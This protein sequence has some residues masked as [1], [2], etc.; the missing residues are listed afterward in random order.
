MHL[1]SFC[2]VIALA[3]GFACY[4]EEAY[5]PDPA[6]P[7]YQLPEVL[8]LQSGKSV[9]TPEEWQKTR[10]G[11]VLELFRTHVY[12]RMPVTRYEQS[13]HV[14]HED[15]ETLGGKATLRQVEIRIARESKSL[16]IRVNLF[17]PNKSDAPVPA[18]VL[19]CNRGAE[20]I[21]PTR[22]KK[23]EFWPVEEGIARS[24]AMAAFLNADVD[25]DKD[26]GFKDGAHGLLDEGERQA[27][28][29]GTIAAWAW[30]A[31]RVLDYLQTVPQIDAKKVA[32]IGHSRGG[33][34][35]LWAAAEDQRFA[36]AVSNDSGCGGAAIS[37][38]RFTG[39][40]QVARITTA[41]PHWFCSNFKSYTDREDELPIDQHELIALI[42]PRAVA[43]GSSSEDRW[44]DPRGEYLSVIHAASVY[45]LFG[46][47]ALGK[48]DLPAI[49]NAIHG[50]QAH[51]HLRPGKHNL[52]LEDWKHYWDFADRV[53]DRKSKE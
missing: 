27:D 2:V 35:A 39:R 32:V 16:T 41:F 49:G 25:P 51:Y 26:D 22:E 9:T 46:H 36:L 17:F 12:G 48:A 38:R 14:T 30:G 45:E 40:E 4:A 37:R 15:K 34:T 1:H 20:N 24:Y 3:T 7:A 31:S 10:R 53:F 52:I 44:A 11:E 13:F 28:S 33:K 50:D 23:S 21:D 47:K 19:I 18:F 5:P 42:A 29:W 6:M 8:K 43:V